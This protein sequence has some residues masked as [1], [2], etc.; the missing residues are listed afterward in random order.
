MPTGALVV[1]APALS[2]ARAVSTWVP[3]ATFFQVN[4]YGAIVSWPSTV[5]P[6]RNS[7][8]SPDRQD[9]PPSPQPMSDVL[10]GYIEPSAGDVMATVGGEFVLAVTVMVAG[11][12]VTVCPK[13][14]VARASACRC[15]HRRRSR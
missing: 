9:H 14:S 10:R 7:T 12:L 11:A 15:R 1:T 13:S 8:F 2:V 3:A 6:S 4:E 5:V